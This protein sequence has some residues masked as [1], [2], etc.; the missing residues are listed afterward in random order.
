MM[1][2]QKVPYP[3][4]LLLLQDLDATAQGQNSKS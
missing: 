4:D 2:Q 1:P 3:F